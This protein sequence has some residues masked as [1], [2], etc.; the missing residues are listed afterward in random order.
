M[1]NEEIKNLIKKHRLFR[2]EIAEVMG[3][4][5]GYL[6]T[7]LRKPLSDDHKKQ[8]IEAIKKITESENKQY[9]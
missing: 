4:S 7:I 9:E 8:I 1:A 6:S 2:Y 5:E 3:V